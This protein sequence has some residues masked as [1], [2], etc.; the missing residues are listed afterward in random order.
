MINLREILIG[1]VLLLPFTGKDDAAKF[2]RAVSEKFSG[3]KDYV[4]DVRVHLD[5]ENVKAPDMAAKIYY[6][7]PDKVKID[8]KGTFLLPKEVGVFNPHMFNPDNFNVSIKDTLQYEGVPAMR[9]SL[10]PKNETLVNRSIILT[11]D[12]SEW[13]IKELLMEPAPGSLMDAKIRYGNFGGFMLPVEIDVNLNLP[14]PDSSQDYSTPRRQ[15][16]G[17]VSGNVAVYYSNYKVNSGLSD[18]L[19]AKEAKH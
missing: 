8:S 13:V 2:L 5:L 19:F 16:R 9:L 3:V 10:S 15:L 6:K 4:V 18:S 17:G 1:F 14:K 7:S 12:R 11:V